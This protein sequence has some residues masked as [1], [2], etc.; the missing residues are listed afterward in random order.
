MN[1]YESE[2]GAVIVCFV[3][4]FCLCVIKDQ[5]DDLEL[6]KE[7][8]FKESLLSSILFYTDNCSFRQCFLTFFFFFYPGDISNYVVPPSGHNV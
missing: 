2:Y 6:E 7:K 5:S 4:H 3:S 8:M 1:R